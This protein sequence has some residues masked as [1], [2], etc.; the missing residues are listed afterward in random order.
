MCFKHIVAKER[1]MRSSYIVVNGRSGTG[2]VS[3]Q[4]RPSHLFRLGLQLGLLGI[5]RLA[6]GLGGAEEHLSLLLVFAFL[7]QLVEFFQETQLCLHILLHL[8]P[9]ITL[10]PDAQ[11]GRE[12]VCVLV[13]LCCF[14]LRERERE[15]ERKIMKKNN[16]KN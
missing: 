10:L 14:I 2:E 9:G 15:R 11:R 8:I 3:V 7:L 13:S 16:D 4:Q 1:E 12:R 6:A 5:L